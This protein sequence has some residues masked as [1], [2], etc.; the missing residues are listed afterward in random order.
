MVMIFDNPVKLGIQGTDRL[1][2]KID[3]SHVVRNRIVSFM[4]DPDE[5]FT[6]K[7]FH[8]KKNLEFFK[9]QTLELY[10]SEISLVRSY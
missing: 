7:D 4:E 6:H 9:K 1:S 3:L 2:G 8:H 10:T 5:L